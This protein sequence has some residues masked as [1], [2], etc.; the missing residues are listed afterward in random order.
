MKLHAEPFSSIHSFGHW[1][2]TCKIKS[3]MCSAESVDSENTIK[4]MW[5]NCD[6][7][8]G[9]PRQHT[10]HT[11]LFLFHVH[12][13]N[14]SNSVHH[15]HLHETSQFERNQLFSCKDLPCSP[16]IPSW[17]IFVKFHDCSLNQ[18][19]QNH[20]VIPAVCCKFSL[21]LGWGRFDSRIRRTFPFL[22]WRFGY[23]LCVLCSS[24]Y[25]NQHW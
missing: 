20:R 16:W 18:L 24:L 14:L 6:H 17:C 25:G 1:Q 10:T 21:K 19:S 3:G 8:T 15:G 23:K 7:M 9:C 2:G 22:R 12:T 11:F 5:S 13:N 4:W